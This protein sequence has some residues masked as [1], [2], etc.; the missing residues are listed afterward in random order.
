MKKLLILPL[1]TLLLLSGCLRQPSEI[2]TEPVEAPTET[3][4]EQ[5][6]TTNLRTFKGQEITVSF[7]DQD[8]KATNIDETT[9]QVEGED[10]R[11][12][13]FKSQDADTSQYEEPQET[14]HVGRQVYGYDLYLYYSNEEAAEEIRTIAESV[15]V[16]QYYR[17]D[18][19]SITFAFPQDWY[20]NAEDNE[21]MCIGPYSLGIAK[22]EEGICSTVIEINIFES[23]KE[24]GQAASKLDAPVG[25]DIWTEEFEGKGLL[26]TLKDSTYQ[27]DTKWILENLSQ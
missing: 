14:S 26:I 17:N 21:I 22:L 4:T 13:I 19:H 20:F 3:P 2:V 6:E 8:Y 16:V 27:E 15:K 25:G 23:L 12:L 7:P 5:P 10:A 18:A 11:L 1:I 24:A 9:T